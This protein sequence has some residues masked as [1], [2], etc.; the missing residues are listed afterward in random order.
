MKTI[1]E[2]NHLCLHRQQPI[3]SDISFHI[4]AGELVMLVGPNGAGKSSLMQCVAGVLAPTAGKL[5]IQQEDPAAWT[6]KEWARHISY[7]PQSNPVN[8]ALTVPEVIR[9]GG[10]AHELYGESLIDKSQQATVLW[11]LEEFKQR[12]VRRLSGGEQQRCH[13]ARSWLQMQ[14]ESSLLWAL[15]EPLSALDLHHQ[16]LCLQQIKAQTERQKSVLM[17][18]HDLNLVR[19]YADRVLLIDKGRL[20]AS[21][22]PGEV[23]SA[24]NISRVFQVEAR[25]EG[26]NVLWY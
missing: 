10:L 26:N 21:G 15:D 20:V 9:L 19:H 16:K 23:L 2:V 7:L 1:L 4:N 12:E 18:A 6:A 17:V 13:M 25:V 8:F 5:L 24:E 14:S 22:T 11:Q 3:L